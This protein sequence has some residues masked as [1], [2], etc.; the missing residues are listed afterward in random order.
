[1]LNQESPGRQTTRAGRTNRPSVF[2]QETLARERHVPG[3]PTRSPR[4]LNQE[5]PGRRTPRAGR[6]QRS[7]VLN[8]ETLADERHVPGL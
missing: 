7:R 4:V 2:N 8:Q 6:I 3:V 1:M 5:S